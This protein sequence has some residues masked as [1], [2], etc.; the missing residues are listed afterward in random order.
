[1]IKKYDRTFEDAEELERF[2]SYWRKVHPET[3]EE[4]PE[5]FGWVINI[6]TNKYI[7]EAIGTP[8]YCSPR[9]ETY[10]CS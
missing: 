8:Y 3:G 2:E 5:G 6:M 4:A 9:S 10:W 1:M 7:L